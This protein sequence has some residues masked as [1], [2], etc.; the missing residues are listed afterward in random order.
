MVDATSAMDFASEAGG[1]F[2]PTSDDLDEYLRA[3]CRMGNHVARYDL[4]KK[5]LS[6]GRVLEIGCGYGAG[7]CLLAPS[8]SEYVGVDADPAAIN[9]ARRNVAPTVSHSA[10]LTAEEFQASEMIMGFDCAIAFEVLEHV[11]QP[12]DW[13]GNL[14]LSTRP[15]GFVILSTPNG[16]SSRHQRTLFRTSFHIDEYDIHELEQLLT[17]SGRDY[18]YFKERRVDWMDVVTLRRRAAHSR[19]NPAAE[20]D[21]E[22]FF[23]KI[24]RIAFRHLNG[25]RWWTINPAI[26]Q[27]MASLDYSSIVVRFTVEKPNNSTQDSR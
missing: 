6:D 4:A 13:I 25:R 22:S 16:A 15:G 26:P 21:S 27:S 5:W 17:G 3:Y 24:L 10:F 12:R 20:S 1:S 8:Y 18:L 19:K 7:A 2:V 9:W 14:I 23:N 11:H